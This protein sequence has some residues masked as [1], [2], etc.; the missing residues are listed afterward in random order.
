MT[1]LTQ[2]STASA[3]ARPMGVARALAMAAL[4]AAAVGLGWKAWEVNITMSCWQDEW[5]NLAACEDIMG[6]TPEE[7]VAKLQKRL[8]DNPGDSQ[9]LVALAIWANP[10][11]PVAG[12][13]GAALLAAA[14]KA[15]PQDTAVLQLLAY[16]AL[17][18]SQWADALDPLI[19]LSRFHAN[20]DASRTIA[21]LIGDA[22]EIPELAMA[23]F[24]A[25]KTDSLWLDRV[26]RAM[27]QAKLP[28]G[29]AMPLI[30]EMMAADQLSPALGQFVIR[31]LKRE[32]SWPEAHEVWRHLWKRDLPLVFNGDFE[33]AFVRDG[34]DWETADANDH[35][36]GARVALVGRKEHGQVLQVEFTGKA[37]RPPILRQDMRLL[38]GRYRLSGS[39]QS[40]DLRSEQGLAWVVNCAQDGR[41]LGRTAGLKPTGRAWQAWEAEIVVPDDC[42]GDGA[43]LTLQTFAPY[44]SKTGLRG[45]VLMDNLAMARENAPQ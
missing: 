6:R 25:A 42:P 37:I 44:E 31:E 32:G 3:T 27:P 5:P 33:Q 36:S 39:M 7:K 23:L 11:D 41:E 12:L 35:R 1:S 22:G 34:F 40:N 26:L 43:R 9:A 38:P 19:R 8:A 4:V 14:A 13:D 15:A 18:N 30:N 17:K 28:V 10:P 2:V 45:E 20:A 16:D 24:S 21:L 29:G